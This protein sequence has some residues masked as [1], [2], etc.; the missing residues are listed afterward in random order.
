[1]TLEKIRFL[2][3]AGVVQWTLTEL[4]PNRVKWLAQVG[5]RATPQQLQRMPSVRRYPVLLAVLSQALHHHTD[6]AVELYDQCGFDHGV[7]H[8]RPLSITRQHH[9]LVYHFIV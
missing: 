6:I 9:L 5:W 3:D 8:F 2:V 4:T 1:M 7:G